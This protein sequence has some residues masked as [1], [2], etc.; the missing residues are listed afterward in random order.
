MECRRG[1]GEK[2]EIALLHYDEGPRVR[3]ER[4]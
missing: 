2:L 3:G 4:R 1:R